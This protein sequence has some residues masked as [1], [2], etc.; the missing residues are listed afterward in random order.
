[1]DTGENPTVPE[2][3]TTHEA[4]PWNVLRAT[5][6]RHA[7]YADGIAYIGGAGLR[8]EEEIRASWVNET[9]QLVNDLK[10]AMGYLPDDILRY[11]VSQIDQ[12]AE[13]SLLLRHTEIAPAAE[14]TVEV[15]RTKP[16]RR[17]DAASAL[18]DA[19]A[20]REGAVVS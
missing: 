11:A 19:G 8:L 16:R 18:A 15:E 6:L 20:D 2:P 14:E 17:N 1:M 5:M 13:A 12:A 10:V 9:R 7:H 4:G 3:T